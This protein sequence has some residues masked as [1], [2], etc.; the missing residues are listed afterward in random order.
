[1]NI[2][3][4]KIGTR[5]GAGFALVLFLLSV[6]AGLGVWWL[7]NVGNATHQM[8][9][10]AMVKERLAADWLVGTSTNSVR[11]FALVKSTDPE[12][13]KYFQK[14]LAQTS[15]G[16]TENSKKLFDMLDTT[17]EKQ[18]YEDSMAK[19]KAYVG[20]RTAALKLKTEGQPEQAVTLIDT[21]LVPALEAYDASIKAMLLHQKANIDRTV[22]DIDLLYR[23]GRFSLIVLALAALVFGGALAWWLTVGI[24]RPLGQ[25]VKVAEAVAGGD[26]SSRIGA[27][28]KDETGRKSVV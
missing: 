18:L 19:R 15:L 1:M 22:S 3:N 25:A 9:S 13:Q 17:E 21:K 14:G 24:T 20:F 16:I 27:S 4:L 26:L 2:G 8:A 7:Q 10:Q 11:T 23:S 5:L 12:D 6:I 28:T